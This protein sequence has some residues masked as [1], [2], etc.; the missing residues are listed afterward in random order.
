MEEQ[1]YLTAGAGAPRRARTRRELSA[2]A[3]ARAGGA[4]ADWV[5]SSGPDFLTR[6]HHRGRRGR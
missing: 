4:F 5:M 2:A 1:G 6:T 3:A